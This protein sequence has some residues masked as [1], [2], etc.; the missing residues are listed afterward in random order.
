MLSRYSLTG[1]S[2]IFGN[3]LKELEELS[4]QVAEVVRTVPSAVDV[5]P[6]Q[7]MA[8]LTSTFISTDQPS[9]LWH[10]VGNS[11]RY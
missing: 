11:G 5:Y 2:E 9:P 3:D 10:D 7:I 8:R 6:E 4:R 1:R